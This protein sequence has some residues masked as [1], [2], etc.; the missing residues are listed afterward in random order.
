MNR[1]EKSRTTTFNSSKGRVDAARGS[2]GIPLSVLTSLS[3]SGDSSVLVGQLLLLLLLNFIRVTVE[4]HVDHN[5]PAVGGTGDGAPET[6]DLTGKEPPDETDGVTGLVVGGDSNI[7]ELQGGI[8]VTESN[9][10]DVDVGSLSDGL[11][12]N[13]GVGNDN[14]TGLLERPGDVVGEATGGETT[15]DGLST[16]VGGVLED[17]TVTVGTS[18]DDTDIV[19]VLN[20]G[21]DT[22]GENELFPGLANVDEVDTCGIAGENW[23]AL[24]E[25]CLRPDKPRNAPSD[26]RFQT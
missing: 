3:T 16:G 10:G 23:Y 1:I 6:E 7:D 9:D 14:K 2:S 22:G 4:E 15:S 25:Y 24:N 19:G 17:G 21:N 5:V 13:T 18:R 12:V 8:G 11:V 26:L 20:S